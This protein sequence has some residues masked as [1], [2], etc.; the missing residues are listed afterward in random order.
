MGNASVEEAALHFGNANVLLEILAISLSDT[1]CSNRTRMSHPCVSSSGRPF[2]HGL[3]DQ[4]E[5]PSR[6]SACRAALDGDSA[7][8]IMSATIEQPDPMEL[9]RGHAEISR[10]G[11]RLVLQM[12][13]ELEDTESEDFGVSNAGF[14]D[15]EDWPR[16]GRPFRNIFAEYLERARAAGADVEAGFCAVVSDFFALNCS[17]LSPDGNRYARMFKIE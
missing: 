7:A 8:T 2:E 14:C 13:E 15:L 12:M 17:G 11:V 1:P 9:W 6:P 10:D 5:A 4:P 16:E 3:H